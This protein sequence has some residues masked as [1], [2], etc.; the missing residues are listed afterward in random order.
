MARDDENNLGY[1]VTL[2]QSNTQID[3]NKSYFYVKTTPGEAQTLEVRI[4]STKKDPVHIKIYGTNAIT[5]DG[6]TIEYSDDKT[7][8]DA[9]LKD[10]ITSMI[11]VQTPD[12]TIGNYEEKTVEIQLTPPKEMYD[13]VK[14][15]AIIFALDQEQKEKSGVSTE[16][17]YRVGVI[18]AESGD[19]F[20]NAQILNLNSVKASIKRGKKMVLAK[21]QNPEPKVLENVSIV[22]TM[23]KKDTAE[24][25]KRKSVEN[26]SMAPN[27]VFD[28]E[29]DWGI[30]ALPSGTYNLKLDAS[31]DYQEWQLSKEFI[32]TNEQ[33]KKMN[34]ESVFKIITPDWIKGTTIFLI[35]VNGLIMLTILFRRKNWEKQWKKIRIAKRKK[36]GT[37]KRK[38]ISRKDGE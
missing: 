24:V 11:Q 26:Y 14:M 8:Y 28:F 3:P 38:K 18:T 36:Q 4:K 25:V 23:T 2:V 34:E 29:M 27:S 6:G 20:N 17:S 10:P 15:G 35:A 19:E 1:T 13:G 16:F 30:A 32:I 5:G 33:A 7:Y 31:N 37:P 9:T 12:L 22:A 21:L